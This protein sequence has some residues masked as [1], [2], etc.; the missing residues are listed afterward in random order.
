[1]L[2]RTTEETRAEP[3]LF[4][5]RKPRESTF[6]SAAMAELRVPAGMMA[7][8]LIRSLRQGQK[9]NMVRNAQI[10]IQSQR[11]S[12]APAYDGDVETKPITFRSA[13]GKFHDENVAL[14]SKAMK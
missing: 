1:L 3:S 11:C 5:K 14:S 12:T 10:S 9:A 7:F 4:A 13:K 2:T 6:G 8:R